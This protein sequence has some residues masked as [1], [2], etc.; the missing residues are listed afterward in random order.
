M[1]RKRTSPI[2]QVSKEKFARIISESRT[3]SEALRCFGLRNIGCN[4]R[5]LRK[6]I[7]ED[8]IDDSHILRGREANKLQTPPIRKGIPI[9]EILVANSSYSRFHLKRRLIKEKLLEYKC[10]QCNLEPKWN[11]KPLSLQLDHKNGISDDNRIENLRFICPNCHSQTDTFAG[12][13]KK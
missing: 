5:T 3:T 10:S 2:W 6:R 9:Q 1:A 11:G 13:N 4:Y 8:Q 12:R 7:W